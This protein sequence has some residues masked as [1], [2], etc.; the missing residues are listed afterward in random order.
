[1]NDD[2]AELLKRSLELANVDVGSGGIRLRGSRGLGGGLEVQVEMAEGP[3]EGEDVV[4]V[5]G[6]R[7]FIDPLV[8]EAFPEAVV[9]LDPQHDTISVR[10]AGSD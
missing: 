1:V 7:L 4:E 6:L 2:A 9:T 8:S 3:E 5:A 10:P